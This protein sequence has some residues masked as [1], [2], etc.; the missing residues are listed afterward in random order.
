MDKKRLTYIDMAKGVGIFCVII[1]HSGT[2][3]QKLIVYVSQPAMP[4]FFVVSGMLIS[5]TGEWKKSGR[6]LIRKKAR[7]LLI[8]YFWFTCLYF[9]RDLVN[10]FRGSADRAWDFGEQLPDFL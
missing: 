6:D 5:C 4:L 3:S 8:P 7:T 9:L 1:M 10:I 2:L